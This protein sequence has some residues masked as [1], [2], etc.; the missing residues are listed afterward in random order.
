VASLAGTLRFSANTEDPAAAEPTP[1]TAGAVE[2]PDVKGLE[3]NPARRALV[4]RRLAIG[5]A[6]DG[7]LP[8]ALWA[9]VHDQSPEPGSKIAVRETVLLYTNKVERP[10]MLVPETEPGRCPADRARH[11][12][13]V[14]RSLGEGPVLL[15]SASQ[16]GVFDLGGQRVARISTLWT[17][18]EGYDGPVLVRGDKMRGRGD[19]RFEQD[20]EVT[21]EGNILHGTPLELRFP[22]R[23]ASESPTW[24][25]VVSFVGGPGC[26]AFQ[27]DGEGFQQHIIVRAR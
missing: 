23:T 1:T 10:R 24:H 4:D 7:D 21:Q 6:E 20:P 17:V 9:T 14:R 3:V 11:S 25:A 16:D 2:V 18:E 26:Y 8:S 5:I 12:P 22:V 27:V 13:A 19:L 15:G